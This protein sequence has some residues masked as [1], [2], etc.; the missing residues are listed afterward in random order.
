MNRNRRSQLDKLGLGLLLILV[1]GYFAYQNGLISHGQSCP[2]GDTCTSTTVT[3]TLCSGTSTVF[4]QSILPYCETTTIIST[5]T[6]TSSSYTIGNN[7]VFIRLRPLD[8]QYT[9]CSKACWVMP[10]YTAQDVVRMISNLHATVL[11]RYTSGAIN[12]SYQVPVCSTCSTM[13]TLQFLDASEQACHC[14][15]WPRVTMSAATS[16]SLTNLENAAQALLNLGVSPQFPILAIDL[17]AKYAGGYTQA[18]IVGMFKA[19]N[20]QGW[21]GYDVNQCGG[22]VSS[23]GYAKYQDVCADKADTGPD[24]AISG[25]HSEGATALVY[26]DFPG[27][28]C[29]F[30]T[31][32]SPAQQFAD[33]TTMAQNQGASSYWLVYM[34]VQPLPSGQCAASTSGLYDSNAISSGGKTQFQLFQSLISQ[35]G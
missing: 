32:N 16:T 6:S 23:Y 3:T 29:N 8:T 13:T 7:P 2:S 18:Q 27:N 4:G 31:N 21:K 35:Y 11:E 30:I 20:A 15:I 9:S 14:P 10:G 1:I 22:Y 26:Y 19:L 34:V 24:G 5:H 12:P 28:I 33:W 25:V 17:W